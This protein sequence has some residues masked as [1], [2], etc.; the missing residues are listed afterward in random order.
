MA[1]RKEK[2]TLGTVFVP[3]TAYWGAQT[4]RSLD[5]FDIARE[6]DIMPTPIIKAFG[7][8]KKAAAIVNVDFGL[9]KLLGTQGVMQLGPSSK[10]LRTSSMGNSISSSLSWFGKPDQERSP[11]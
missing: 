4:Q 6:A 2:D 5:N 11:I 3:M 10:Q 1:S 7:I 9:D 8:L